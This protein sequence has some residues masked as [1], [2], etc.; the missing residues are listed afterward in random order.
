MDDAFLV[1]GLEPFGDL[2]CQLQR[3][4]D[5]GCAA[6]QAVGQALAG[7]QLHDQRWHVVGFFQLV[8]GGDVGV[9]ERRQGPRFAPEPREPIRILRRPRREGT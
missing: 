6:Q 8:D 2:A 5:G 7:H 1:R 3:L 4:A 9:V